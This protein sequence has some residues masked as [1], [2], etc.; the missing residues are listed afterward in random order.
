MARRGF[1]EKTSGTAVVGELVCALTK[2]ISKIC[3]ATQ[4]KMTAVK[5]SLWEFVVD[6]HQ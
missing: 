5:Y 3:A 6:Q 2:A 4:H 1:R